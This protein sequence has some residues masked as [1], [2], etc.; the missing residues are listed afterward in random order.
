MSDDI[1][2]LI[3]LLI[4]ISLFLILALSIN[5]LKD[6]KEDDEENMKVIN[7]IYATSAIN[8][9]ALV[10]ISFFNVL[11]YKFISDLVANVSLAIL[12][13][14]FGANILIIIFA[15]LPILT[16]T[17]RMA[18]AIV[19][20]TKPIILFLSYLFLIFTYPYVLLRKV[21]YKP[22]KNTMTEDEFL[23]M[24]E[25]AEEEESINESEKEL[26][27][28]VLDFDD[29]K[30]TDIYTPRIDII[31]VEKDTST[32]SII[33]KFK[34][35]GYSRL[36][37]Y[38][39]SIDNIIGIINH[40]DFYNDVVLEKKS[41]E[42]I[43]QK[44]VE[45]SEYME[46]KNLLNLLKQ[47]KSHLAVVKDEYGGTIGLVTMEDILE[48]LVGDIWDEHDIVIENVKKISDSRYLVIGQT[49]L[50]DLEEILDIEELDDEDYYTVN[51]WALANLGKMGVKGDSF[52]YKNLLVTV[53]RANNKQILEVEINILEANHEENAE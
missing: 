21:F 4:A 27:K 41:L 7:N 2:I 17:D 46:L 24:I 49:Y 34:N 36:P 43:I 38:E 11:L 10:L 45:V 29:T 40:K 35:S 23:E 13:T 15:L 16:L 8:F 53:I 31:A 18:E 51:G 28:S 47:N 32:N 20:K 33:K 26:I 19:I 42:S 52:T 22:K 30:I 25:Q 1:I 5:S 39:K 44:P 37:V 12:I 50:E 3:V 6:Y 9:I 48:E 14:I